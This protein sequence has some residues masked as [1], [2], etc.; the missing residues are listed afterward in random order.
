MNGPPTEDVIEGATKTIEYA[1]QDLTDQLRKLEGEIEG[2]WETIARLTK[3][4]E[5]LRNQLSMVS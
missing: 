2:L 4:N 5:D 3:E 1:V